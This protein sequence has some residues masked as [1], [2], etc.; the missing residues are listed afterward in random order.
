ML[1]AKG[2]R[3]LATVLMLLTHDRGKKSNSAAQV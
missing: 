2:I 3:V 1:S